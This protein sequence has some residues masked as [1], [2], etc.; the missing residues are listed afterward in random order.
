[1]IY[2]SNLDW[3][4]QHYQMYEELFDSM[5]CEGQNRLDQV[6]FVE[7][8]QVMRGYFKIVPQS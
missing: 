1:M 5:E 4:V 2:I 3:I 7:V 8:Q 6:N